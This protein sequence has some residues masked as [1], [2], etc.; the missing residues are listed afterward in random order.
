MNRIAKYFLIITAVLALAPF[1]I[2]AQTGFTDAN[3]ISLGGPPGADGTV[4]AAVV[5]AKGNLYIGGLFTHVNGV[6]AS[7]IARWDGANWSSLG[8]G[9]AGGNGSLATFVYALAL[10]SSGNLYAAGNFTSAGGVG[11]S[12]IARWDGTNWSALGSGLNYLTYALAGDKFGNIYAGGGFNMA[13]GNTARNVAKWNGSAWSALGTGMN[14]TVF[15]LTCDSPGNLYAVGVFTTAGGTNVNAVA[16]WN[17]SA[18]LPLGSGLGPAGGATVFAVKFDPA[19]KY[20]Y[21]GGY[22]TSAG[23]VGANYIARWNGTNWSGLG[24]EVNAQVNAFAFDV[25]GNLYAGGYFNSAGGSGANYVAR[26]NGTNWSA[27]GSGAG[28]VDP[29]TYINALAFDRSGNLYVGGRYATAGT[30]NAADIAKAL[31][32]QSSYILSLTRSGVGTNVI[33]GLGTPGY[34]YALDLATNL[35]PSMNWLP[36]TTNTPP[37]QSLL[38]TNVNTSP[39]GFYRTRY[40]P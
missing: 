8:S 7:C 33:A 12:Y 29:F 21:V 34:G 17:G 5:D 30:N 6:S 3:W 2:T 20:L 24:S 28:P 35:A 16:E 37:D 13:G 14:N 31:L 36:Q 11:A 15:G 40:V 32:S 22:L 38:Y 10:D 18:W 1:S 25:S 26:W 27:L 23:G 4:N 19:E 9:M 39:Q